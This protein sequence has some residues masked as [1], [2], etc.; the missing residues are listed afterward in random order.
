MVYK[1]FIFAVKFRI[2]YKYERD[3]QHLIFCILLH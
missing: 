1:L 2:E 3:R